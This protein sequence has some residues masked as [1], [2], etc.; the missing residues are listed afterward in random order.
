MEDKPVDTL[1]NTQPLLNKYMKLQTMPMNN[2]ELA[3]F[4]SKV[5][6][7][8]NKT[9]NWSKKSQKNSAT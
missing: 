9:K 3:A 7:F 6:N 8:C 1:Y 5:E 4:K 2:E